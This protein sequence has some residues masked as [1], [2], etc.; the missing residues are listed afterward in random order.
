MS[1][2]LKAE[3]PI[4]GERYRLIAQLDAGGMGSV[5]IAEAVHLSSVV[6]VKIMDRGLAETPEAAQ[7]FLREARTA[8][9]LRSPHVVQI[10]DYG[11]Q[12]G[13]PFIAMELLEGESLA[14]RLARE[15]RLPSWEQTASWCATR[16]KRSSSCST[17]AS[18]R[19]R[20]PR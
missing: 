9:S 13:T 11:V 10:L 19:R 5:W 7:R 4:L 2:M 16:R 15:G 20:H 17:S 8:A 18:P 14:S 6:A 3:G 1:S 12:D